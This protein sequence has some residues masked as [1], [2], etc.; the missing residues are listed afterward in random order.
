VVV[1]G[2]VVHIGISYFVRIVSGFEC[3]DVVLGNIDCR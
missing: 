3:D 2:V 1:A